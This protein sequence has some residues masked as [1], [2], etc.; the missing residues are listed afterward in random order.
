MI[1]DLTE[2]REK[3]IIIRDNVSNGQWDFDLLANE[4]DVDQ[5]EDWGLDIP[6]FERDE[7]QDDKYTQKIDTPV[8]EPKNEKPKITELYNAERYKELISEIDNSSIDNDVKAMLKVSASRHIVFNYE[9]MADYYAHSSKDVQI[10]MENS[11][12]VIIDFDK[13]IEL[14][15]VKLKN[16]ISEQCELDEDE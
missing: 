16:E 4:W 6:N 11:A 8:Y 9:N 12:L 14:N 10:L 1:K 5:L 2:E 7:N 3:E 13:A 15:Y